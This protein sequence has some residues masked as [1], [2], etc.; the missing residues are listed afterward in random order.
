MVKIPQQLSESCRKSLKKLGRGLMLYL[1]LS[2]R[3]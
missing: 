1:L 2:E 3:S